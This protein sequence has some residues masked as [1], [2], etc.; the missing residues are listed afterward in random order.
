MKYINKSKFCFA[1]NL[2]QLQRS[3]FIA[4]LWKGKDF[5]KMSNND[6]VDPVLVK[7]LHIAFRFPLM[8][9]CVPNGN[10]QAWRGA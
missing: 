6:Q 4:G 3:S 1:R 9:I 5:K 2:L 10:N 8:L 7:Q